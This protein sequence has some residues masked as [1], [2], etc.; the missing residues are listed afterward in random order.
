MVS[1]TRIWRYERPAVLLDASRFRNLKRTELYAS[2]LASATHDF[3][4]TVPPF[5]T[6]LPRVFS[7]LDGL[8]NQLAEQFEQ[9]EK[10]GYVTIVPPTESN[11]SGRFASVARQLVLEHDM[12][13]RELED[14]RSEACRLKGRTTI[15]IAEGFVRIAD[16][17]ACF[18]RRFCHH[19]AKEQQLIEVTSQ[20]RKS[21]QLRMHYHHRNFQNP[22]RERRWSS[23]LSHGE[24]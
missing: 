24:L 12:L 20:S 22:R 17:F 1:H 16:S 3:L 9:E 7:V 21:E 10:S 19:E 2:N 18:L 15:G 4:N 11:L 8:Q 23:R 13:L 14:I 6:H 5:A